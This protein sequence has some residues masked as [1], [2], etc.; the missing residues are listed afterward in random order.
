MYPISQMNLQ[1][2]LLSRKLPDLNVKFSP[3]LITHYW[4]ICWRLTVL[5]LNT[6]TISKPR[7]RIPRAQHSNSVFHQSFPGKILFTSNLIDRKIHCLPTYPLICLSHSIELKY[8][9]WDFTLQDQ[10]SEE[11][12][13]VDF[14][15]LLFDR[16]QQSIMDRKLLVLSLLFIGWLSVCWASRGGF[17]ICFKETERSSQCQGPSHTCSGW[18]YVYTVLH[19][20]NHFETIPII[21]VEAAT[22]NGELKH[23]GPS[24]QRWSTASALGRQKGAHSAKE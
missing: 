14:I 18:S 1:I 24:T 12:V 15:T 8:L 19:G 16:F 21:E 20:L 2:Q 23:R 4:G 11:S 9:R 10:L 13:R 7:T 3:S 5:K 17:R 22:T 6:V